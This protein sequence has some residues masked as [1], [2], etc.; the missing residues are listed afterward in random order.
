MNIFFAR[1]SALSV[2]LLGACLASGSVALA[3][4]PATER[5]PATENHRHATIKPGA[6]VE[7]SHRMQ[8][9]TRIGDVGTAVVTVSEGY[10]SGSLRLIA[11]ASEGL[12]LVSSEN[13]ATLSMAGSRD[14]VVNVRF[15]ARSEGVHYL[16][17]TGEVSDN[18]GQKAVRNFSMRV[19]IG[20]APAKAA[21]PGLAKDGKGAPII[22]MPAT[23][24]ISN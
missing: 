19:Q 24:T 10:E 22:L 21:K 18:A 2:A 1:H 16:S 3:A 8:S 4:P 23:E 17:L 13:L 9:P 12:E 5:P 11:R 20:N 6:A 7:F 14:H 15:R